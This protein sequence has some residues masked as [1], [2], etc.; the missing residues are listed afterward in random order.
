MS[1]ALLLGDRIAVLDAGRLVRVG[2]PRAL[3]LDPG[4]PRVEALLETPRRQLDRIEALLG[5]G[6]RP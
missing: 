1:E 3:L 4:D 6:E 5:E 2:S